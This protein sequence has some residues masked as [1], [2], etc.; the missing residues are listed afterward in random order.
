MLPARVAGRTRA[1]PRPQA[2]SRPRS[3][4]R[5]V[6]PRRKPARTRAKT[7]AAPLAPSAAAGCGASCLSWPL[8][9]SSLPP[10]RWRSSATGIGT[11]SRTTKSLRPRASTRPIPRSLSAPTWPASP[12]IGMP[13]A[14]STPKPSA[15]YYI[16]GTTINLPIVHTDDDAHYLKTDFYGETNW[17]VSFGAIFLSAENAADFSDANNI[18]YGHH[19]NDGSMFS[20]IA[21]FEDSRHVQRVPHRVH[22]HPVRKLPPDHVQPGALR[23]RRPACAN[24]VRQRAGARRISCRTR[25]DRSVVSVEGLPSAADMNHTF[26]LATCDN[27]AQNGRWVLFAYVAEQTAGAAGPAGATSIV[28]P[29]GRGRRR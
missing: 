17:A 18:V 2:S 11:A 13:C 15:G 14:P 23:R 21:D 25:S 27:S 6:R 9:C 26:T 24:G 7:T 1:R 5:F 29:R 3:P 19:M 4:A 10:V 12:L 8:S 20:P 22:F 16:P 28:R